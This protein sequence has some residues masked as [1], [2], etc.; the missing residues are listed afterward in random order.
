MI[1]RKFIQEHRD[2]IFVYGDNFERRGF[3]GQ[4]REARGESNTIGIPTKWRP[5]NNHDSFF[6]D[7]QFDEVR[8]RIDAAFERIIIEKTLGRKIIFFPNIGMGY[9]ALDDTAPKILE[10][11]QKRIKDIEK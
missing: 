5:N 6:Y 3:A 7:T 11:I 10:Y 9:A 2:T 4:A 1:T 8:S